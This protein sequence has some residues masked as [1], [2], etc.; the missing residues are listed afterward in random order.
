MR[1]EEADAGYTSSF[2]KQHIYRFLYP[3]LPRARHPIGE[4]IFVCLNF[5]GY[6]YVAEEREWFR[7]PYQRRD[8]RIK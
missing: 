5:F 2:M 8:G 3:D 1:L 7:Y 4:M 6:A